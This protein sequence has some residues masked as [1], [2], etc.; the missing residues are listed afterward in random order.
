MTLLVLAVF[1][2][3]WF[4]VPVL[5]AVRL[6]PDGTRT[7]GLGYFEY[8]RNGALMVALFSL[9]TLADGEMLDARIAY[10]LVVVL[11]LSVGLLLRRRLVDA[12]VIIHSVS[13]DD[14][15]DAAPTSPGD[16]PHR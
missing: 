5:Y 3:A 16:D 7:P 13:G 15:S 1:A 9:W 11:P 6:P 8:F 2:A 10:P 12:N 4:G 14:G